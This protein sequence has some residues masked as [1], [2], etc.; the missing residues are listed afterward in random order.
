M[1]KQKLQC[2]HIR[3]SK[4]PDWRD[5]NTPVMVA[6]KHMT[7]SKSRFPK[8]KMQPYHMFKKPLFLLLHVL[9]QCEFE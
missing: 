6:T 4:N 8:I 9:I 7:K 5:P 1:Q 3:A 2:N